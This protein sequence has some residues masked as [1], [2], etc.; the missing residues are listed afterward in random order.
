MKT[1]TQQIDEYQRPLTLRHNQAILVVDKRGKFK[2]AYALRD[3]RIFC[4]TMKG[5]K[6]VVTTLYLEDIEAQL[7]SIVNK[8]L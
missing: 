6:Q 2:T 5:K 7:K 1:K 8:A 3:E 4:I